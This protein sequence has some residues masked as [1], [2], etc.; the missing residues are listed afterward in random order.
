MAKCAEN[1][2]F[3][4]KLHALRESRNMTADEFADFVGIS[5]RS[6]YDYESGNRLPSGYVVKQICERCGVSSDYILSIDE[7]SGKKS[8]FVTKDGVK[9]ADFDEIENAKLF[10]TMCRMLWDN[11][12][13]LM[14]GGTV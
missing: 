4:K 10:V 11:K 2:I 6:V 7:N 3:G 1:N 12:F 8:Y 5:G 9:F 13:S 14:E